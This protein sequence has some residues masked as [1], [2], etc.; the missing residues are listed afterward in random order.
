M[1]RWTVGKVRVVCADPPW[2]F[3]DKLPGRSRG[4]AKNYSVMSV[5]ELCDMAER[6]NTVAIRYGLGAS[7]TLC[8]EKVA[9][10]ND[11]LLFMW[12]VSSQVEE[13]YKVVREWGFVP[14]TE[15]VW[16]KLTKTGKPWFGLGRY[17]RA[18]HETCIVAARGRATRLIKSRS[19]RSTFAAP[20]GRHSEK[21]EIFYDMVEELARGP[22]VELFARRRRRGWTCI[23]NEVSS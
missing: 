5:R 21:P 11:A 10:A 2:S 8:E 6:R 7:L 14:K 23:G 4:A 19:L 16:Q 9:I 3:R 22:Y 20:A 1:S 17:V 18:S 12:R 15:I 13:A